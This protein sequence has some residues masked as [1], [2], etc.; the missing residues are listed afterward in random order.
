M[1]G[2][3]LY[4]LSVLRGY[5]SKQRIACV[6]GAEVDTGSRLEGRV[7]ARTRSWSGLIT[8]P[9]APLQLLPHYQERPFL[10][11]MKVYHI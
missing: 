9:V 6:A 1:C 7:R 5:L 3:L 11:P 2:K 8:S 10:L 4:F